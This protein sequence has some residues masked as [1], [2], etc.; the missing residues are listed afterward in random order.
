MCNLLYSITKGPQAIRDFTRALRHT[1]GNFSP[2]P[3]AFPD[4][5]AAIVRNVEGSRELTMVQGDA[6]AKFCFNGANS[7]RPR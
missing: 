4:Y 1:T 3:S 6:T 5:S 7:G 2:I